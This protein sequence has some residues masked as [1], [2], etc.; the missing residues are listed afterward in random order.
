MQ[1]GTKLCKNSTRVSNCIIILQEKIIQN[2]FTLMEIK[3]KQKKYVFVL[4]ST[5]ARSYLSPP[6]PLYQKPFILKDLHI[7]II[8]HIF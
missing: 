8:H 5:W 3:G 2:I 7:H 6:L 4:D 1:V